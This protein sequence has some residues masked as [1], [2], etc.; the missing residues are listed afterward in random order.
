ME[1]NGSHVIDYQHTSIWEGVR[2]LPTHLHVEGLTQINIRA[3]NI[4]KVKNT[5]E[6]A[7]A[8]LATLV[9]TR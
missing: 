9:G 3:S 8:N 5:I 2:E 6:L 7:E 4:T 1:T